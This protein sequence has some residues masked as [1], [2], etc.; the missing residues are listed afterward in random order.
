MDANAEYDRSLFRDNPPVRYIIGLDEAG[1][2]PAAGPLSVGMFVMP[3]AGVFIPGV[4]DSKKISEKTREAL[5]ERITEGGCHWYCEM[6]TPEFVDRFNVYQATRI[7]M[8]AMVERLS[9]EILSSAFVITD[10][11]PLD[12]PHIPQIN[13]V[14]GDCLSYTVGCASVIAK[15]TRDR[16]MRRLA[17]IYPEYGFDSNKGYCTRKH[18]EALNKYGPLPVH[19]RT[20]APV[21]DLLSDRRYDLFKASSTESEE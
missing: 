20:F 16:E 18:I 8:T 21:R 15:V 1:R 5:F 3:R 19:R 9:D 4:T 2:G 14:K 7:T 13:P 10:A 11:V 12:L 6:V 17:E